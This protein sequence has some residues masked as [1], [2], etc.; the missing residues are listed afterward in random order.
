MKYITNIL[1][2]GILLF[3]NPI[4]AQQ[5]SIP[6][7][8]FGLYTASIG[9]EDSGDEVHYC[10]GI[11]EDPSIVYKEIFAGARYATYYS[12]ISFDKQTGKLVLKSIRMINI[13]EDVVSIEEDTTSTIELQIIEKGNTIIM[14]DDNFSDADILK[15]DALEFEILNRKGIPAKF[16]KASVESEKVKVELE[17]Y[18]TIKFTE[19]EIESEFIMLVRTCTF[20]NIVI[21]DS[22]FGDCIDPECHSMSVIKMINGDEIKIELSQLFKNGGANVEK[23]I[24]SKSIENLK[25]FQDRNSEE[26]DPR[27]VNSVYQN[28]TFKGNKRFD[29]CTNQIELWYIREEDKLFQFRTFVE[30]EQGE[31]YQ[32][33][34]GMLFI[35]IT[36]EELLPY[37]AE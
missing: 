36:Y 20:R 9:H 11:N 5:G 30:I 25:R 16:K 17:K 13:E 31:N 14:K 22:I 34:D 28:Y 2:I 37:F 7:N 19:T 26:F 32:Q 18:N 27:Y 15:S 23:I 35:E 10:F 12:V 33:G 6:T 21:I 8:Y 4:F 1:T 3:A 29:S 24:N